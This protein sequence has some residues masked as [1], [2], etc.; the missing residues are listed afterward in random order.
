[1]AGIGGKKIIKELP[2][3]DQRSAAVDF[4]KYEAKFKALADQKRLQIMYELTQR[5]NTCVCD[6]AD[7]VE[8]QHSTERRGFTFSDGIYLRVESSSGLVI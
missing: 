5:E 2:D 8:M 7:I 6:F 1:M 4:S 3:I